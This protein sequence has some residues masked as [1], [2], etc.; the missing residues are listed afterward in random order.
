MAVNVLYFIDDLSPLFRKIA[1]LLKPG[2]RAVFDLRSADSLKKHALHT[3]RIS[4]PAPGRH[5]GTAGGGGVQR[6][7]IRLSRRGHGET[8]RVGY[9]RRL[10]HLESS[11]ECITHH[12]EA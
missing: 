6:L 2:G 10:A 8:G 5:H 11:Q 4:H 1:A 7:G 12:F 9:L 3:I